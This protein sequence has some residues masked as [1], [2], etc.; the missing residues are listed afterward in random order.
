MNFADNKCVWLVLPT[1]YRVAAVAVE[2]PGDMTVYTFAFYEDW[3]LREHLDSL[4]HESNPIVDPRE[5]CDPTSR[6][7]SE[8]L[9]PEEFELLPKGLTGLRRYAMLGTDSRCPDGLDEDDG[10]E[11]EDFECLWDGMRVEPR[12]WDGRWTYRQAFSSLDDIFSDAADGDG[13]HEENWPG[14]DAVSGLIKRAKCLFEESGLMDEE[15]ES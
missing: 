10:F 11:V 3:K 14:L 2:P 15:V 6:E 13:A 5:G 4:N 7:Y 1:G 12:T 9:W 8:P